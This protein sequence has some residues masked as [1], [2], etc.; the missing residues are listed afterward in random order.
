MDRDERNVVVDLRIELMT[1][2]RPQLLYIRE[3]LYLDFLCMFEIQNYIQLLVN[4]VTQY[5][6]ADYLK[7]PGTPVDLCQDLVGIGFFL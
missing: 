6:V 3:H 7:G 5:S 4:S 1:H 2:Q